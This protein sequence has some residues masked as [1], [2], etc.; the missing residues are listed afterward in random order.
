MIKC[1]K[2][3]LQEKREEILSK[4]KEKWEKQNGDVYIENLVIETYETAKRKSE[5]N[6][7]MNRNFKLLFVGIH[8][9]ACFLFL[10]LFVTNKWSWAKAFSALALCIIIAI[11][12]SAVVSK[13]VDIKKYQETWIR[14][15]SHV[16]KMEK[17]ML[18]FWCGLPPYEYPQS[19]K[20]KFIQNMIRVWSENHDKFENNMETKE[21]RLMEDFSEH[22]T[23]LP[24]I[25]K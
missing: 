7:K 23:A 22:I 18:L 25:K 21:K 24:Q 10:S 20:D 19:R 12:L 8:G 13:W 6:K 3:K 5:K 2:T 17:E 16:Q 14:Q 1:K 11:W 9:I 4:W 15:S